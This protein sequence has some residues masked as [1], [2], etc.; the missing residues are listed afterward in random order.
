M[1]RTIFVLCL[2]IVFRCSN[3]QEPTG[4][5]MRA[6]NHPDFQWITAETAHFRI[7]ALPDTRV[8][9][10]LHETGIELEQIRA[11]NLR[12]LGMTDYPY[13]IH[14]FYITTREQIKQVSG[15]SFRAMADIPSRTMFMVIPHNRNEYIERHEMMHVLSE[16]I[17]GQSFGFGGSPWLTEGMATCAG[18]T[19]GG[20]TID[21]IASHIMHHEKYVVL[22]SLCT[23][24]RDYKELVKYPLAG[25]FMGYLLKHYTLSRVRKLWKRGIHEFPK[26]FRE[27]LASVEARWK[28]EIMERYPS[29]D[30]DWEEWKARLN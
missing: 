20:Y 7:H 30:F 28:A 22:D 2:L 10:T 23:R 6:L 18:G 4:T 15:A 25:S 1:K 11:E 17:W 27:S 13:P 24:F 14:V 3:R 29:P 16:N 5:A 21:A 26:I 12:F 19:L 9:D 8:A